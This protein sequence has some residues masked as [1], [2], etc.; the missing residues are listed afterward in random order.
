MGTDHEVAL[1]R[2]ECGIEENQDIYWLFSRAQVEFVLKELDLVETSDGMVMSRYQEMVLPVLSLEKHFALS[3]S[4]S[5]E[6][7]KFLVL[8]SVDQNKKLHRVIVHSRFSPQFMKLNRSFE[9]AVGFSTPENSDHILG[10]YNLS[11]DKIGVVPDVAS[12]C[13]NLREMA[14]AT[15]E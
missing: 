2:A 1:V 9:A 6:D 12:I 13:L 5:V 11:G 8:R 4:D 3:E 10:A 15:G 7:K 14:A